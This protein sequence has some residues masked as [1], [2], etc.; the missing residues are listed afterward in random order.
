MTLSSKFVSL[1][2]LGSLPDVATPGARWRAECSTEAC[3]RSLFVRGVWLDSYEITCEETPTGGT[4][5][6]VSGRKITVWSERRYS[7]TPKGAVTWLLWRKR[8]H[9]EMSR[10]RADSARIVAE[11]L[12]AAL[13]GKNG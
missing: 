10:K 8:Y 4:T 12:S 1:D 2:E 13:G 11:A 3:L 9:M 6:L 7:K 5:L